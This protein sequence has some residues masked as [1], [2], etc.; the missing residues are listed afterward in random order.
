MLSPIQ[1]DIRNKFDLTTT[2][3]FDFGK[4]GTYRL[5]IERGNYRVEHGEGDAAATMVVTWADAKK[6]FAGKLDPMVAVMTGRVKTRGNARAL[7]VL[8]DAR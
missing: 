6:M 4:D 3:M 2:F 5:M 7:L 8:Q 1:N